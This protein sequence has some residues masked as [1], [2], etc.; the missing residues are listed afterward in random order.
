[1]TIRQNRE[2]KKQSMND[3]L[4]EVVAFRSLFHLAQVQVGL[5]QPLRVCQGQAIELEVPRD[6]PLQIDGEP[7]VMKKCFLR[8]SHKCES[9]VLIPPRGP[10]QL[11]AMQ[12]IQ[13]ALDS[14][15]QDATLD[16]Y[17]RNVLLREFSKRF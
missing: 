1:M 10:N 6:T 15:V 13:E 17:Q 5:A 3:R 8:V 12:I 9:L 16:I 7:Q 4:I 2:W 11:E 14:A